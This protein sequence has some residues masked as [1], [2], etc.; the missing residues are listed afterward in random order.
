MNSLTAMF[1]IWGAIML[2][3]IALRT[4][5]SRSGYLLDLARATC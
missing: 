3:D 4:P 5:G 1:K 2:R